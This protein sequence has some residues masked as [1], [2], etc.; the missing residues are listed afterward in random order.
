MLETWGRFAHIG[1]IVSAS[2]RQYGLIAPPMHQVNSGNSAI[3]CRRGASPHPS[4]QHRHHSCFHRSAI[5]ILASSILGFA[6]IANPVHGA[7][8]TSTEC[9]VSSGGTRLQL[10][11]ENV[12]TMRGSITISVYGDHP[13]DFLVKGKKVAKVRVPAQ[14]GTFRACLN[15]PKPGTYAL[16][17][18]HD[19]DGD[20][21]LTR[22]FL[23][24]PV[25][26]YAFSNDPTV[27]LAPPAFDAVAITVHTAHNAANLRFHYP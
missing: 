19:E 14:A 22:N 13:E 10:T 6:T 21:R 25:E 18:Y 24:V 17:A 2:R 11:I 27:V 26:G 7:A 9:P 23:G 8:P 15:L 12:R 16:A 3:L 5:F 20:G 1:P 4:K